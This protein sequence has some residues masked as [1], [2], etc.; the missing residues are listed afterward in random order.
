MATVELPQLTVTSTASAPTV[1]P[2]DVLTVTITATNTGPVTYS[3]GSASLGVGLS[4]SL[5]DMLDDATYNG[6]AVATGA[7]GL[8]SH[9]GGRPA[10]LDPH[11]R[12]GTGRIGDHHV[13]GDRERPADR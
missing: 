9:A 7:T 8:L 11:R 13:L 5:V 10:H 1:T 6:D 3:G 4:E 12:H 2:G